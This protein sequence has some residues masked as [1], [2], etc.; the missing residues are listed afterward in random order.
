MV[1][2]LVHLH[3]S[4][5]HTVKGKHRTP[6]RQKTGKQT[7]VPAFYWTESKIQEQKLTKETQINKQNK[8]QDYICKRR[9]D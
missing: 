3:T 9:A 7:H 1:L 4:Y 5:C 6:S 2:S 8:K